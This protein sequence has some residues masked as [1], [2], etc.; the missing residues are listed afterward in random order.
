MVRLIFLGP[1]GAGKGT[2]A[3]TLAQN[4]G[5]PHISTG[6]ILRVAVSQN[7]ALGTQAKAYMDK[8]ELVPD[9]LI[10]DMVRERLSQ[11]DAASGWILDGF[12]R[13]VPQAVFLDEL[14]TEIGQSC[15]R[16][17]NF[18]VPDEALVE[19]LL[20]RGRKDDDES[21]V[22]YRL[23]VYRQQTAPLIGFYSDR[24]QLVS[25]DGS[26]PLETVT[27]ALKHAIA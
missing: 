15:D 16:V 3:S 6:D 19:R 22:R 12:P 5:I 7:T 1:P 17:V 27:D 4:S 18:E 20:N 13:T 9:Q 21:V 14:L 11:D 25:I 24:Q 8:G 23:E 2:Q 10:L 26:Q